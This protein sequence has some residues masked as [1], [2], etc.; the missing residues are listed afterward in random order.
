MAELRDPFVIERFLSLCSHSDQE[1]CWVW[2]GMSNTN[3]YGRFSFNDRHRLAHRVSFEMFI[4][5]IPE[6]MVVCH[7]CDNRLCVNPRHLWLGTQSENLLDAV[8]KGRKSPPD[9][10]G[11]K[12]GN[13]KLN[14]DQVSAIRSMHAQGAKKYLIA[15]VFH[16]SPS[17]IGGIVSNKSW[18]A[19]A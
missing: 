12:N 19:L 8:S 9:T 2:S 4:G 1:R 15:Q 14:W 7:E 18:K 16:V 3:G 5:P 6:G 17:T 10:T 13:R 11:E